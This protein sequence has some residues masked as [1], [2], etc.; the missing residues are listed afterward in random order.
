MMRNGREHIE[1]PPQPGLDAGAKPV[2]EIYASQPII[3]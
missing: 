3:T 1:L 2:I